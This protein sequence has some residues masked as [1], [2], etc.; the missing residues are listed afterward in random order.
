MHRD[1]RLIDNWM[2][3]GGDT[4][5]FSLVHSYSTHRGYT[6]CVV[7]PKRCGRSRMYLPKDTGS[8]LTL[9][10]SYEL[11]YLLQMLYQEHCAHRNM[12]RWQG[13]QSQKW[14]MLHRWTRPMH[15]DPGS[16]PSR[17]MLTIL[18]NHL[19]TYPY[20]LSVDH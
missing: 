11:L 8:L 4:H 12:S 5:P 18:S 13:I 16:S 6:D 10:E 15:T 7:I 9:A 3:G 17:G 1:E 19:L 20:N 14:Q 2:R